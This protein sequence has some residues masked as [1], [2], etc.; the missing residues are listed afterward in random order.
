[1]TLTKSIS[2]P[3]SSSPSEGMTFNEPILGDVQ[4]RKDKTK[5]KSN[6]KEKSGK[7]EN[8]SKNNKAAKRSKEMHISK[9]WKGKSRKRAI[10]F[11]DRQTRNSSGEV[12]GG[13]SAGITN[14]LASP[15][16]FNS[17]PL[18][19]PNSIVRESDNIKK[20]VSNMEEEWDKTMV[21]KN[22]EKDK[23]QANKNIIERHHG[24]HNHIEQGEYILVDSEVMLEEF[25]E[26]AQ[27]SQYQD[28]TSAPSLNDGRRK[29]KDKSKKNEGIRR[30]PSED[31]IKRQSLAD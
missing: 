6:N 10:S 29:I 3:L 9:L 2:S 23:G 13:G 14:S 25:T 16:M 28:N 8:R 26:E 22:K 5:L 19:V 24:N 1:M 20:S 11:E 27:S 15:T 17:A 12:P 18:V 21:S 7:K 31:K 30:R 4:G